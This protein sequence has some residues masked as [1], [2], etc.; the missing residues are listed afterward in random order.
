MD[1]YRYGSTADLIPHDLPFLDGPAGDRP[2]DNAGAARVE[3]LPVSG[4]RAGEPVRRTIGI[5][6][7]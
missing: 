6:S 3:P 4:F 7:M 5:D 1:G 2:L